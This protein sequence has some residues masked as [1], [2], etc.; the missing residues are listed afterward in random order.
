VTTG[1]PARR[2]RRAGAVARAA[3]PVQFRRIS[4]AHRSAQIRL[5]TC[6][7][8]SVVTRTITPA[9]SPGST[10][11]FRAQRNGR[12]PLI[13]S[14]SWQFTHGKTP[15]VAGQ[16]RSGPSASPG[17]SSSWCGADTRSRTRRFGPGQL[18]LEAAG[19]VIREVCRSSR[20]TGDGFQHDGPAAAFGGRTRGR[21]AWRDAR[22]GQGVESGEQWA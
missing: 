14:T 20:A 21:R 19:N 4:A 6:A 8:H 13:D 7:H 17:R 18:Q 1:Q 9:A 5:A 22:V 15:T 10:G 16:L 3:E 2:T 11:G 12:F